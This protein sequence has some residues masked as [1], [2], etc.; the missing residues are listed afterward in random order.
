MMNHMHTQQRESSGQQDPPQGLF[1]KIIGKIDQERLMYAKHRMVLIWVCFAS[2]I[3]A[4]VA[5]F[6]WMRSAFADSGSEEFLSLIFSDF[7]AII[8]H[9]QSY[10]IAVLESL[11]IVN[12]VAFLIAVLIVLHVSAFLTKGWGEMKNRHVIA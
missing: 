2:S 12:M 11:P 5:A 6:I 4:L 3:G 10:V 9:W 1:K 7:D 8:A